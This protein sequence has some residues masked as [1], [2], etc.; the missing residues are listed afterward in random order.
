MENC[1]FCKIINGDIPSYTIYEDDVVKVFLDIN[2][3][4]VGHMLIIPKKHYTN[5]DDI[6]MTT[7][8]HIFETS[9]KMHTLLKDK[10]NID[11][12]SVVQNNGN[13]QEVKHYHMHI[14]P[15][16]ENEPSLSVEDTYKKLTD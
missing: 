3:Q 2:P 14:I 1:I 7:L 11:G 8:N 10:L 9:K 12:M 4:T 5:L 16:Y 13:V 15:S 6:D